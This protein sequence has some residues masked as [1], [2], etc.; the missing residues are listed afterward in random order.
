MGRGGQRKGKGSS[1]IWVLCEFGPLSASFCPKINT[2][3][4]IYSRMDKSWGGGCDLGTEEMT[5]LFAF[6]I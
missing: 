4:P 1:S 5:G 6:L 2:V 3:V